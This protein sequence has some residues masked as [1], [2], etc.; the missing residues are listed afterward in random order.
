MDSQTKAKIEFESAQFKAGQNSNQ[1]RNYS[2]LANGMGTYVFAHAA[3]ALL[4]HAIAENVT[5]LLS[6]GVRVHYARFDTAI[7][8]SLGLR[9]AAFMLKLTDSSVSIG[10]FT[11]SPYADG[12]EKVEFARPWPASVGP[13]EHLSEPIQVFMEDMRAFLLKGTC[14]S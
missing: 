3:F 1:Q 14:P 9:R 12:D 5:C 6:N 7:V 4:D 13:I 10:F 2:D 11:A 8:V